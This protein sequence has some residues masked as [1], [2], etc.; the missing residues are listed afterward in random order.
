MGSAFS[1]QFA[2][3]LVLVLTMGR[4]H[5]V[6][7]DTRAILKTQGNVVVDGNPALPFSA[8][9]PNALI[10][11]RKG[12]SALIEEAGSHVEIGPDTIV[13]FESNELRL[14]HGSLSV[15]TFRSM[16]VKV[17]CIVVI[18]AR[19]QET[20][21]TVADQSGRVTVS[22][23]RDDVNI[24]HSLKRR[25]ASES[26][27][28]DVTVRQGEQKSRNE[29][30]GAFPYQSGA[31]RAGV[32]AIFNSPYAE[33]IGAAAIAGTLCWLFCDTNGNPGSPWVP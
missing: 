15:L 17:G 27:R 13:A 16:V 33:G 8:I 2:V 23:V 18:P 14:D 21:F 12:A 29:K 30:C 5:C 4:R 9:F 25:N 31:A 6:A 11:T 3:L 26:A 7:D 20:L 32:A 19:N 24:K 10:E 28:S 1:K 22:A